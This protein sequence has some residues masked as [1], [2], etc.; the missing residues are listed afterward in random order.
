MSN[1]KFI[2]TTLLSSQGGDDI[3]PEERELLQETQHAQILQCIAFAFESSTFTEGTFSC[4]GQNVHK[5]VSHQSRQNILN[6]VQLENEHPSL[7]NSE[8]PRISHQQDPTPYIIEESLKIGLSCYHEID[9]SLIKS[10][11]RY[12]PEDSYAFALSRNF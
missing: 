7:I 10:R 2:E 11:H 1:L 3:T 12:I 5:L 8:H 4:Q 9:L 6:I